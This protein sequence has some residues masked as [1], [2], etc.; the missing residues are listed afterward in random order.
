MAGKV[1]NKM[2]GFLGLEDDI[3]EE[4]ED[5]FNAERDGIENG[6]DSEVESYSKKNNRVV[7]IH[8]T[9]SAKVRIVKPARY[10][11]AADIVDELKS[12]KIILV[13]TTELDIKV[14]QR[15]LDFMGG[16]SFALGGDLQEIDKGVFILSP[17][18]VEVNNELKNELS[19]KG[20]FNWNK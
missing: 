9:I 6:G 7:S 2:M 14:A 10:E 3:S 11:E 13:N 16:A 19:S 5:S 17:S 8:T 15:F 20:L 4:A 18:N 12:R 1:I